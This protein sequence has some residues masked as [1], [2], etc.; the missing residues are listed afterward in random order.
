MVLLSTRP[1]NASYRPCSVNCYF[2]QNAKVN[3]LI[4]L[5]DLIYIRFQRVK[6]FSITVFL[7]SLLLLHLVSFWGGRDGHANST[8]VCDHRW[9]WAKT[10]VQSAKCVCLATFYLY[11]M[12]ESKNLGKCARKYIIKF[13]NL[14]QNLCR[15]IC[16]QSV[17]K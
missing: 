8:H 11:F 14:E 4:F 2:K 9:T 13:G 5:N 6:S 15:A 10:H 16:W 12:V 7:K 1:I 17:Q 3:N